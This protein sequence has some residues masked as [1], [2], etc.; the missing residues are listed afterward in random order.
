MTWICVKEA[1]AIVGI[2]PRRFRDEWTPETGVAQVLYRN[3]NGKTGRARR[4][5]VD[6]EDLLLVLASRTTFR[7][8]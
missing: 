6:L 2:K 1:A 3:A 4:V 8:G 5:D 7:A